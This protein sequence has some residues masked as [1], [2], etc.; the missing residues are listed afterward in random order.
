MGQ[1][2]SGFRNTKIGKKYFW[3]N[4]IRVVL[5]KSNYQMKKLS[6]HCHL[7]PLQLIFYLKIKVCIIR[8]T[9]S[10]LTL[11]KKYSKMVLF[12]LKTH[13]KKVFL[14]YFYTQTLPMQKIGLKWSK[15]RFLQGDFKS[16]PFS[17][18]IQQS[19][20]QPVNK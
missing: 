11:P 20:S 17:M 9:Y 1:Y 14:G 13:F 15:N 16:P 8:N 5:N 3:W 10:E 2:V 19:L 18:S 12:G 6:L 7:Q 4:T